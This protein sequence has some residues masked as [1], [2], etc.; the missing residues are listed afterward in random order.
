MLMKRPFLF[1]FD[2]F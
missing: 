1:R 2:A